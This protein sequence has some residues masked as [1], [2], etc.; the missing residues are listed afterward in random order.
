MQ[1]YAEMQME[2]EKLSPSQRYTMRRICGSSKLDKIIVEKIGWK[3]KVDCE[4]HGFRYIVELGQ[5]GRQIS[6]YVYEC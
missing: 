5:R 4:T 3:T 1:T 6:Y 2:I